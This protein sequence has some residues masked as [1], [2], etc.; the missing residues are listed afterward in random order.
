[1]T[2]EKVLAGVKRGPG[3]VNLPRHFELKRGESGKGSKGGRKRPGGKMKNPMKWY[4][5]SEQVLRGKIK[6]RERGGCMLR[7]Y[8]KRQK[9]EKGKRGAWFR[10]QE[11]YTKKKK[12]NKNKGGGVD[13]KVWAE[14]DTLF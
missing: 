9:Q 6:K 10:Q 14:K 3:D 13:V 12:K 7:R 11:Q 5:T 4:K 8:G 2:K 1:V